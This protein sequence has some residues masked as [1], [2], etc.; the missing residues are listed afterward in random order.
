ML[1]RRATPAAAPARSPPHVAAAQLRWR[2]PP[3]LPLPIRAQR[4]GSSAEDDDDSANDDPDARLSAS[5]SSDGK[6]DMHVPSEILGG[7]S[8]ERKAAGLLVALFTAIAAR[9][10]LAQ[11]SGSGRGE[12]G[13]YNA[14]AFATL[15]GLMRERR[16]PPDDP[17]SWL[18]ELMARD[19]ALC[20]RVIEVRRAYASR[21]FEY[22]SLERLAKK[23]AGEG[24]VRLMREQ[25]A[26]SLRAAAAGGG[27]GG[28]VEEEGVE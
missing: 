20:R 25:A 16:V 3:P 14:E 5:S 1:L 24:G 10:V 26:R 2:R 15:E 21:Q 22:G 12:L 23:A 6:H 4:G 8:P 18:A 17:D 27:G 11:L 13:S 7:V 9:I 19:A 28:E